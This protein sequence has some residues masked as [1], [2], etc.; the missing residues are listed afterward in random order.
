LAKAQRRW[1]CGRVKAVVMVVMAVVVVV[2]LAVVVM[3][4]VATVL[5]NHLDTRIPRPLLNDNTT[6]RRRERYNSS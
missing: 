4:G 3:V 2:V 5:I 1:W 6:T